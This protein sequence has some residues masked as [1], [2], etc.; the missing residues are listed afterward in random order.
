MCKYLGHML[1][2]VGAIALLAPI[3]F[4]ADGTTAVVRAGALGITSPLVADFPARTIIGVTQTTTMALAAFAVSDLR[5]SGTGWHVTAQATRFSGGG[6]DLRAG[7]L[8]LSKPTVAAN[9]TTSPLPM[10]TTSNSYTIDNGAFTMASAALDEG[11]GVYDF[12]A[13]TL[14]LALPVSVY[15]GIYIGTETL[16]VVA[17]P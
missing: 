13:T 3:A 8:E 15:A 11:M 14:T 7:S 5:G 4:A 6:H 17:A 9:G 10:V 2:A 16:S 1:L 12:S